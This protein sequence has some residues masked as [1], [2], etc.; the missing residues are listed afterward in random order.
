MNPSATPAATSDAGSGAD[1]PAE[2]RRG[3]LLPLLVAVVAAA[4]FVVG[5]VGPPLFGR[6]VFQASDLVYI[7]YPWRAYDDP[8]ALNAYDHGPVSDTV[9]GAYPD[10]QRFAEGLQDRSVLDWNPWVQGGQSLG[11]VSSS[12]V[13]GPATLA[14]VVFPGW[15]ALA[16]VKAVGVALSIGFTYLFCRRLGTQRLPAVLGGIAFAGSGFMVMWTNWP[17]VEVA[18]LIP[19]LFWATERFLQKRTAASVVPIAIA[20]A[21]ML[22]PNFPAVAGYSLYV[23]VPYVAVRL[24]ADHRLDIKRVA[25]GAVGAASGL[26]AGGLL[27]AWFL[28]PFASLL[29]TTDLAY[30]GQD[31]DDNL[32]AATLATAVVPRI[33]GL[34]DDGINYAGPWPGQIEAVSFVG[35]VTVLLAVLAVALPAGER[36]PRAARGTLAA[37]TLVIGLATYIGGPLL[38]LLQKLP[39][40]TDSFIGRTRSVLGFLVAVLAALGLQAL[41]ERRDR[42][43]ARSR[44][45]FGGV[46]GVAALSA[47]WVGVLTHDW[48]SDHG[49]SDVARSAAVLPGIVTAIAVLSLALVRFGP[50][51]LRLGALAALPVLL[52][53]E[54]L[55]LS[56]PLLP[57]E[58]REQFYPDTAATSFLREHVGADRVGFE[59]LSFYGNSLTLEDVRA[60]TGHG[61]AAPT[62]ADMLR[63]V[64]HRAYANSNTFS[65]LRGDLEVV[66]NPA[67]DRMGVRWFATAPNRNLFGIVDAGTI[68]AAS[69]DAPFTLGAGGTDS[70]TVTLPGE[71]NPGTLA[72]EGL[73]GLI[74]RVCEDAEVAKPAT[75]AVE[76]RQ[77]DERATGLAHLENIVREGNPELAVAGEELT[78][79]EDI[80]VELTLR[81]AGDDDA[82][83]LA[84]T[85]Y[86]VPAV[87]S[88]RPTS[89][90]VRLAHADDMRIW[91][92]Q[93]ALPRIR[94]A[95]R[96]AVIEDHEVRLERL[97]DGGLPSD[98]VVLSEGSADAR[99]S[100]ADVQVHLD[101]PDTFTATVDAEGDGHLVL[102]DARQN[103]WVATVDG[104]EVDLVDADHAG[105]A[106]AV[107]AGTHEVAV[108]YRPPGQRS[109][110]L[111]ALVT[112]A[113]LAG[114][115]VVTF[116]RRRRPHLGG[117]SRVPVPFPRP[118]VTTAPGRP[119]ATTPPGPAPSPEPGPSPEPPVPSPV[120]GPQAQPAPTP[121]PDGSPAPTPNGSPGKA[122]GDDPD[123]DHATPRAVRPAPFVPIP[124]RP[125]EPRPAGEG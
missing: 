92:R 7:A 63:A 88:V 58:P 98:T 9:D 109:G 8:T 123:D 83:R 45:A 23:L 61:F 10:R 1:E 29:G 68:P 26:A 53:V 44:L 73:R 90:G 30:R 28:L 107:P 66:T 95:G 20:L 5:T 38:G 6:G 81:D 21:C 106:V 108:H 27:V 16:V 86:G 119:G 70:L 99:P 59:G 74:V 12:G 51:L 46:V 124:P 89:D 37:A 48:V 62:W 35:V 94:W 91:E 77:G 22:L 13:L 104:E 76:A 105:V 100:E 15:Y 25:T 111:V 101:A 64:D 36:A 84:T 40:F 78:G 34:S 42:L 96:A 113:G 114:A 112:A 11:G 120:P 110:M 103:A 17:Q 71:P 93:T 118:A 55:A 72:D 57:N 102:A 115:V 24:L 3:L 56:M 121:T 117:G 31:V 50:R 4:A 2:G 97:T 33:F 18:A 79:D 47:V 67:L 54:S 52:T 41:I 32:R 19:A 82:I 39:V 85:V 60:L 80:E 125:G 43:P 65:Q 87:G 122:A 116:V 14:H 49:L 69:C 75:I